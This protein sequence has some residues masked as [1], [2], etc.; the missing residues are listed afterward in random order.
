VADP[1][2]MLDPSKWSYEDYQNFVLATARQDLEKAMSY[3]RQIVIGWTYDVPF[4]PE[5]FFKLPF[6]ELPK[7]VETTKSTINAYIEGL[8]DDSVRVNLDKWDMS[9]FF[10]F[11]TAAKRGNVKRVIAL[12]RKVASM[13]G[14]EDGKPLTLEQGVLLSRAVS[15]KMKGLFAQGN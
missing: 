11:Q 9:E 2:I 15:D 7:I 3:V 8:E 1:R 13:G 10:E 4:S 14:L 6:T 5:A 12:L